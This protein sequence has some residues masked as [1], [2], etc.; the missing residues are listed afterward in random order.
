MASASRDKTI[1]IWN[2]NSGTLDQILEGHGAEVYSVAVSPDGK[3]LIS[4]SSD[5]SIKIWDAETGKPTETFKCPTC[6]PIKFSPDSQLAA[7]VE[8]DDPSGHWSIQIW[9]LV[10]RKHGQNIRTHN[11]RVWPLAFAPQEQH[12]A[13]GDMDGTIKIWD[14][15][16]GLCLK[17]LTSEMGYINSLAYSPDGNR[18]AS[19]TL[20]GVGLWDPDT[21]TLLQTMK[22]HSSSVRSVAFSPNGKTIASSSS[23]IFIWDVTTSTLLYT[24]TGHTQNVLSPCQQSD[25]FF[26]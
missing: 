9:S 5:K 24:L 12:L 4:T 2:V 11:S 3:H 16:V 17:T 1:C 15:V 19:G 10:T 6:F 14:Y 20:Y 21:G 18:L 26:I 25:G 8:V 22:G 23:E 13:S 7:W